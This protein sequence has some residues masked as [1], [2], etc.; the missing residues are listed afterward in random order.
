MIA[1]FIYL[2]TALD[3]ELLPS[4]NYL[5]PDVPITPSSGLLNLPTLPRHLAVEIFHQRGGR[6]LLNLAVLAVEQPPHRGEV[7]PARRQGLDQFQQRDGAFAAAHKIRV[8]FLHRALRQRGDMPA[9]EEDGLLRIP[10][11]DRGAERTRRGHVLSR[12]G[13]LMAVDDDR[14]EKWLEFLH[15]MRHLIRCQLLGLGVNDDDRV[16]ASPQI[17]RHQTGPYRRL[18]GGQ[19]GSQHLIDVRAAP[20]ID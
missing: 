10:L 18:D 17:R 6:G 7:R 8:F 15:A 4:A 11:L 9:Y 16:A 20:P 13:R 14:R 12:G 3:F 5:F 2:V 1:W 19:L